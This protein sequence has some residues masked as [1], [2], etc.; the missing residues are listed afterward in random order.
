[1]YVLRERSEVSWSKCVR[2]CRVRVA[3][4]RLG[5]AGEVETVYCFR[6]VS[7]VDLH[8]AAEAGELEPL[9]THHATGGESVPGYERGFRG[10]MEDCCLTVI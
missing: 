7:T 8:P 3:A 2:R 1:M 6:D 9:A 5:A 4:E 10:E